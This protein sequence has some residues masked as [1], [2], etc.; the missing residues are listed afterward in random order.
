MA[1]TQVEPFYAT[2]A[3][4]LRRDIHSG[5]YAPGEKLPSEATLVDTSGLAR[6]TVRQAIEALVGEGLIVSRSGR[7]HYVRRSTPLV[8]RAS[9]PERNTDTAAATATGPS[10]AWS[11][12]VR[13][14]GRVPSEDVRTEIAYATEKVANWLQIPAGEPVSVRRRVRYVDDE[15]YSTADSFYP[16]SIVAGTEV[17]LPGDVLPGIYSVFERL[18]RPWQRT[19]DRVNSR[20]ATRD[21][22]RV[23]GVAR[24]VSVNEIVRRSFDTDGIPVR[25]TLIVLPSDRHEIEYEIKERT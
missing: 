5:I 8:W 9:D 13:A 15:P 20:Q 18:G 14:Q 7:G 22:A 3:D 10:D 24:G 25:L 17:E 11:R 21:E 16:R 4:R 2:L 19:V 6:G 12:S 1:A 23:L